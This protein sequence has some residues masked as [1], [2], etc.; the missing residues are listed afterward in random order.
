MWC[1]CLCA[2]YAVKGAIQS[3]GTCSTDS[4]RLAPAGIPVEC[5]GLF[6]GPCMEGL[7]YRR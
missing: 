1:P 4:R 3:C 6:M 5:V 2:V 7:T